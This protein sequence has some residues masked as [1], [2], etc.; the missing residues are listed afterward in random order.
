MKSMNVIARYTV[1]LLLSSMFSGCPDDS[2]TEGL[3]TADDTSANNSMPADGVASRGDVVSIDGEAI[4]DEDTADLPVS[5]PAGLRGCLDGELYVCAEDGLSFDQSTCPSGTVCTDGQCMDCAVNSDCEV[6]A[7]CVAGICEVPEL[8]VVT[9]ALPTAIVSVPY[10]TQ[11]IAVG[12]VPPYEWTA[13][14]VESWPSGVSVGTDGQFGGVPQESGQW[15]LEFQVTDSAGGSTSSVFT[16]D[17]S[18]VGLAVTTPSPL[19]SALEG[20]PYSVTFAADGGQ[21]PYFF[22]TLTSPPDGLSLG[23]GGLLSGTPLLAG[24]YTFDLKVFDNGSPTLSSEKT[25]ELAVNVAPLQII[26][27]NAVDLFVAELFPLPLIVVVDGLPV[28]YSAQ[29]NAKGGEKPYVWTEEP[30]PGF[31]QGFLPN[32]GIPDGLTLNTDG[33]ITGAVTDPNL[34]VSVDIPFTGISLQGFFFSAR[35]TDAQDPSESETALYLIPTVP[36]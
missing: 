32:A 20:E 1:C 23:P 35:V 36:F 28:P 6:G 12:G 5:C 14:D 17:V 2:A 31:V 8:S 21:A 11:I 9:M 22:G 13:V 7:E 34:V 4:G 19:P 18:E 16:F 15:E 29:L 25:F 3:L 26:G 24:N 33:S 30:L 10:L 27:D